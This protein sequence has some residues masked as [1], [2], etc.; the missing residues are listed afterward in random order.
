MRIPIIIEL[1]TNNN[2]LHGKVSGQGTHYR[3]QYWSEKVVQY[4]YC[5]G[6]QPFPTH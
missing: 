2:F 4:M 1:I 5:I 3:L 6:G